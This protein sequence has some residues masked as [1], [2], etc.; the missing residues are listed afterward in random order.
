M[1]SSEKAGSSGVINKGFLGKV[2]K[3]GNML[4]NP[5]MLFTALA[6][7]VLVL[8]YLCGKAGVSVTYMAA[9]AKTGGLTETTVFVRNLITREFFQEILRDCVSI[10]VNFA[11]LGTVMVAMLGIGYV[12]DVG[13]FDAF[14]RKTL[15]HCPP[16]LITFVIALVGICANIS[17]NAGIIIST[18]LAAAIFASLGRNPVL[19]AVLGYAAG[20]GGFTANLLITADDVLLSSISK[21]AADSAAIDF[22]VTPLMNYYFMVPATIL[23]AVTATLV[24]EKLMPRYIDTK[25]KLDAA[26]L[27]EQALTE[28]QR[29]G[30]RMAGWYF[31]VFLALVLIGAIPKDGILRNDAGG[32]L[33][34]SPMTEGVVALTVAM[35]FFVGTGYGIGS[36]TIKNQHQIPKLMSAGLRDSLVYFVICFPAA[37]F[38]HFFGASRLSVILS[39]NGAELL[40]RFNFTGIPLTVSFVLLVCFLNLFL[41]SGSAKWMILAPI[42]VPMFASVGISPALTQMAYRIG[43]TSTNPIAPINYFIPII[44]MIMEKYKDSDEEEIGIG[45]VISMTLPYSLCYIVVLV[46]MLVVWMALNLPLGPG[47]RLWMN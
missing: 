45:N 7:I 26:A 37:F 11:P 1:S 5:F 46:T 28:D 33:P 42:F 35:F 2:A 39:V 34:N 13:F 22:I 19:G 44:I 4:P 32:F 8:S 12:Q 16:A 10:Y 24:T 21:A 27:E 30:L 23:M 14:I 6:V 25:G 47:A 3:I 36:R 41:T 9:S 40:E 20:H 18:T 31:L 15:L 17:G 43:D 38:I 29:R